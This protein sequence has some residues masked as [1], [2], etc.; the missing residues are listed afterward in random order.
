MNLL[1]HQ[2]DFQHVEAAA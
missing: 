2:N 1:G